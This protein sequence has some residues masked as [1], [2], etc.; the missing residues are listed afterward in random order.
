MD[1]NTILSLF[2]IYFSITAIVIRTHLFDWHGWFPGHF[3]GQPKRMTF[4]L[5]WSVGENIFL[6]FLWPLT[7]PMYIIFRFVFWIVRLALT[8]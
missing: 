4:H 6:S 2:A 3:N 7:I 8:E 1:R 5:E